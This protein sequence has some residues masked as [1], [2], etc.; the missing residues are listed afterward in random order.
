[1]VAKAI[2]CNVMAAEMRDLLPANADVEIFDISLH[3]RPN[4]LRDTLQDAVSRADGLYDPVFL[5]YGL[6]SQATVGLVAKQ[7]HLVLFKTDDCIGV[8][9]GSKQ[10]QRQRALNEPGAYFLSRGWIGDDTGSL[11][12]EYLRVKTKRGEEKARK[13]MK[14]MLGH[15]DRIAHII[16]PSAPDPEGDRAYAR[17]MAASFELDYVE[18]AGT[19]ELI[20][21]MVKGQ[22]NR[23]VLVVP[24]GCPITLEMMM[25]EEEKDN[26]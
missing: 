11:F 5:G 18:I 4:K 7:S 20:R 26:D 1:M 22:T 19:S 15:Y 25:Q 24:P 21:Q 14:K 12:D 23:D 13:L 2:S 16:M 17:A 10:E 6:C 8:F 9:L 3:T